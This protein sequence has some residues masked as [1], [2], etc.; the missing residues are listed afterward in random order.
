VKTL[1]PVVDRLRIRFRLEDVVIIADRGMV[2]QAAIE[3]VERRRWSFILGERLRTHA[4]VTRQVL[5][6]GGKFQ[7]VVPPR[8]AHGDRSPLKVKDVYVEDR[9]YIVCLNVDQRERDRADRLAI[10]ESLKSKLSQG[11]KAFVGNTGYRRYLK[12]SGA[13][14]E[15]DEKAVQKDE[16]FDGKWVLRTNLDWPADLVAFC[17][18]QLWRVEELFRSLKGL[19]EARPVFHK[20]D[21]AIRGHVFCAFLALVLR[22]ELQQRLAKSGLKLE[23]GDIIRDLDVLTDTVIDHNGNRFHLRSEPQGTAT[24]VFQAVGAAVPPRLVSEATI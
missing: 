3:E 6:R 1:V 9:R 4:E 13:R 19:L 21:E 7:E 17:Y 11:T 10:L 2:S 20:T 15:I 22:Y 24:Q 12:R 5:S 16:R 14:F 8:E 23:W 18:K